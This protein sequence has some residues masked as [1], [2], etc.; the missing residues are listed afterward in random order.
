M[1]GKTIGY[2]KNKYN[3][4][5]K[6]KSRFKCESEVRSDYRSNLSGRTEKMGDV[7]HNF[8]SKADLGNRKAFKNKTIKQI[9]EEFGT[10]EDLA[11]NF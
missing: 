3:A 11:K 5:K 6:K 8:L 9:A 1:M 2:W 10:V 4:C 7:V